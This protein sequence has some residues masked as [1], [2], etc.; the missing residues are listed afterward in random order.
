[1]KPGKFSLFLFI[2]LFVKFNSVYS[3]EDINLNQ[4]DGIPS[5]FEEV[6]LTEE[7]EKYFDQNDINLKLEI[8]K[9]KDDDPIVEIKALDKISAK[10]TTLKI[11]IGETANFGNLE[12]K[13][14]K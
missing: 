14:L 4:L 1:M 12:I 10:T 6:Q 2:L 8:T 13:P 9:D 11:K 7:E 5:T 3:L